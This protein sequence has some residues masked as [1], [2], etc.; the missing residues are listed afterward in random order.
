MPHT[1]NSMGVDI[2]KKSLPFCISDCCTGFNSFILNLL[3]QRFIF[4]ATAYSYFIFDKKDRYL[5]SCNTSQSIQT[6]S[7]LDI[8]V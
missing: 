3:F 2:K 7:I 4:Y 8:A 1:G 6:Y 5:Q